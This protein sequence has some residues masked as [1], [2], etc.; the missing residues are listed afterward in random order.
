MSTW[1]EVVLSVLGGGIVA[2]TV[3]YV[4]GRRVERR[5][6]EATARLMAGERERQLA[7]AR[8]R[9]ELE[10]REELVR[11]REQLEQDLA[12]RRREVDRR[13]SA[14]ERTQT[15][16]AEREREIAR[17]EQSFTDRDRALAGREQEARAQLERLAGLSAQDAKEELKRRLEEEERDAALE[18]ELML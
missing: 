9:V 1:I 14:L 3:F 4:M 8:A 12:E 15:A 10:A 13:L 17:R 16:T 2:G 18:E 11:A 7:D 5:V 6:A